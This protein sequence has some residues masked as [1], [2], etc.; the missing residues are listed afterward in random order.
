MAR[1][2][3]E[4]CM[5]VV[6]NP[7][8]LVLIASQRAKDIGAGAPLT[9]DRDNDKN[10]VIALR[11]IAHRTVNA[12]QLHE[13]VIRNLQRKVKFDKDEEETLDSSTSSLEI[14]E[15]IGS[16]AVNDIT[17]EEEDFSVED[18]EYLDD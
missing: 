7:Y 17:G 6:P 9:V 1:I 16:Y 5:Q 10:A 4:D 8:E 18:G 15:E 14:M 13:T 3:V 11:E 2:T 12:A